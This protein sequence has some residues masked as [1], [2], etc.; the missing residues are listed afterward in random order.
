MVIGKYNGTWVAKHEKSK[1]VLVTG[2]SKKYVY[3]EWNQKRFQCG[4]QK[5]LRDFIRLENKE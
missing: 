2:N 3:F 1:S 4:L 5:F